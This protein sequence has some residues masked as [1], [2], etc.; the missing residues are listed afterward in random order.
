MEPFPRRL[1]LFIGA[2]LLILIICA[3]GV[4]VAFV[5][6]DLYEKK[7]VSIQYFL[8]PAYVC[9]LFLAVYVRHRFF[10]ETRHDPIAPESATRP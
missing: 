8:I 9:I 2:V 3:I 5:V 10:G 7:H 1:W 4:A 6:C